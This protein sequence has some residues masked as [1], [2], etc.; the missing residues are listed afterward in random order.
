M[1]LSTIYNIIIQEEGDN[2]AD[3]RSKY[4]HKYFGINQLIYIII[5][6]KL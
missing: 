2:K 4:N 3:F 6:C 1:L 5:Y